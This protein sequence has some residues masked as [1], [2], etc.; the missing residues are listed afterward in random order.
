MICDD[1]NNFRVSISTLG[2]LAQANK[3]NTKDGYFAQSFELSET[4][5]ASA[6]ASNIRL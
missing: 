2:S 5:H 4:T 1:A 3:W 6:I